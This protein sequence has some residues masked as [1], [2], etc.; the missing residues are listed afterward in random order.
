MSYESIKDK[1]KS[2]QQYKPE[3]V[4]MLP[5]AVP[6]VVGMFLYR[7]KTIPLLDLSKILEID[8]ASNSN[9]V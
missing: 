9:K 1:V 4:T 7:N 5:E 3:L 6:G 8:R 2:I